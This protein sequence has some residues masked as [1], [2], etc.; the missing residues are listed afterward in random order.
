MPARIASILIGCWLFLSTFVWEQ[1]PSQA[2]N[3]WICGVLAASF[4]ALAIAQPKIRYFNSALGIWLFLSA[5]VLPTS[6]L[7]TLWN[8]VACGIAIFF[9][10]LVRSQIPTGE[11]SGYF[12]RRHVPV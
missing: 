9:L 1:T 7:K 2:Y 8:C 11:D 5:W 4:A 3:A 6:N 10:S 12:P